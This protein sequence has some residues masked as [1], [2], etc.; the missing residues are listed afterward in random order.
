MRGRKAPS[1]PLGQAGA[2]SWRGG[3]MVR[4]AAVGSD[5]YG[6]SSTFV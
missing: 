2:Y 4:R 1:R 6:A 5:D 3:G